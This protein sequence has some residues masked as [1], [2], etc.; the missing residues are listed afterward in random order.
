[1]TLTARDVHEQIRSIAPWVD[2]QG[3]TPD[4]FKYGDPDTPVRAIAVGWQSLQ[5]ALEEADALGCNLFITHEPTFYAHM[6]DDE[7]VKETPPGRAKRAFLERTGMVVYRCHDVWDIYPRLGIVDAWGEFL[8]LGEPVGGIRFHNLYAVP[9]TSAWELARRIAA[10]LQP[11][12]EQS[13]Q[14]IGRPWQMVNRLAIGTGAITRAREMVEMGADVVLLTDDG[15]STWREGSWLADLGVPAIIVN[16]NTAE[17]PGLRRLAEYLAER[18]PEVPVHYVGTTCNVQVHATGNPI[19]RGIRM[20]RET[21]DDLPPVQVPEGYTLRPM[22]ADEAWAYLEVM[23]RSNYAG[24]IGEEWFEKT[25]SSDPEYDPSFLQIIWKGERPVA[26]AAAWHPQDR[27]E[28]MGM[29]HWVGA[30]DSE[31]GKGLGV[32]VTAAVL[33]RLRE[34]GFRGAVLT[35]QRWRLAAIAAYMRLGFQPWPI[36]TAPQEVWDRVLADLEAWRAQRAHHRA[37]QTGGGA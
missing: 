30:L 29:V 23:N 17:V 8:G 20:R 31:R 9:C 21:L 16:H 33:H 36:D 13:V 12:G 19:D 11:L 5:S 24:E 10:R 32:A 7:A 28:N 14:F 3:R 27:S 37:P 22:A 4:G 15:M 6:D 18:Y 26:A 1:M 34:R 2:W 25:F 35:T